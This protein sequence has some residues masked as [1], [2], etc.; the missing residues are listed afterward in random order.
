MRRG[1]G[2]RLHLQMACSAP[3][4]KYSA[5]QPH[6]VEALINQRTHYAQAFTF[7]FRRAHPTGAAGKTGRA[8]HSVKGH[9][10][11]HTRTCTQCVHTMYTRVCTHSTSVGTLRGRTA[12]S[13]AGGAS[14]RRQPTPLGHTHARTHARTER[15]R[16]RNQTHL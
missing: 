6:A 12:H 8:P 5:Q 13:P 14:T 9:A 3:S 11:S 4:V 10:H 2:R 15:E 7:I 1:W 16:A